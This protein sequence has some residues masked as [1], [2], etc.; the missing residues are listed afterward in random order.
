M[1][2]STLLFSLSFSYTLLFAFVDITN[3][4]IK[5]LTP[6]IGHSDFMNEYV[7]ALAGEVYHDG[8]PYI[9]EYREPPIYVDE[10]ILPNIPHHGFPI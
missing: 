6:F 7:E 8:L 2:S 5:R 10:P 4:N 3:R 9:H 1:L